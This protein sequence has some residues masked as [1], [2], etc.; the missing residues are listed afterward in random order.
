MPRLII[1]FFVLPL[2]GGFAK[3]FLGTM[4]PTKQPYAL[5]IVAKST[6]AKARA[7]QKVIYEHI[8]T[9]S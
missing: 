7:K 9:D 3:C 8:S 4:M 1:F 6:L 5:K 2:Q